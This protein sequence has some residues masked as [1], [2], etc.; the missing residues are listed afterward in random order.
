MHFTLN[1]TIL[2]ET[3][4]MH[5]KIPKYVYANTPQKLL[6]YASKYA[7]MHLKK[8]RIKRKN[9]FLLRS[10]NVQVCSTCRYIEK[11]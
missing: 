10:D 3:G 2:L 5:L 6:K 7:F 11:S 9:H 1:I 8:Y 4:N